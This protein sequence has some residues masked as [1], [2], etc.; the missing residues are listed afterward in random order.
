V[1]AMSVA[2]RDVL[3]GGLGTVA[4]AQFMR[5]CLA[6][7]AY[8]ATVAT[9]LESWHLGLATIARDFRSDHLTFPQWHA[10]IEDLNSRVPLQDLMAYLKVEEVRPRLLAL[11]HGEH[12]EKL[13]LPSIEGYGRPFTSSVFCVTPGGAIPPHGH[14]NLVTAHLLLRGQLHTRTFERLHDEPGMV[15][16]KPKRDAMLTIGTTVTM[17][18]DI[19]NIH[20]FTA[21][22]DLAFSF[23]ISASVPRPKPEVNE[24]AKGGRVYLDM[25]GKP[26]SDGTIEAPVINEAES[27]RLFD[28]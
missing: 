27:H 5:L 12:F 24:A 20:W 25:R 14:N 19:E 2:R 9:D 18:D 10:A 22:K 15:T 28:T 16:V 11:G 23:Q 13:N 8:A 4:V 7:K 17:S 21:Q 3:L 26:R 6:T 1:L